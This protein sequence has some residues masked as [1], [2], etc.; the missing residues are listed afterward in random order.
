MLNLAD[1]VGKFLPSVGETCFN[2]L[3]GEDVA[4]YLACQGYD[5]ETWFDTGRNGIAITKC[6]YTVST[7]GYVSTV[8][9]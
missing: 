7:N 1:K 2:S 8:K 3:D 6:G 9:K 5:I 4:V